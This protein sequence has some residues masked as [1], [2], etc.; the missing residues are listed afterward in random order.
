MA[1]KTT[2]KD[3]DDPRLKGAKHVPNKT[4]LKTFRDTDA[5]RNLIRSTSVQ[6]MFDKLGLDGERERP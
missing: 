5:G 1:G 2:R 6:E 3:F 4:T